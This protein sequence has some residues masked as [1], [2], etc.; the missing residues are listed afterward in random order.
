MCVCMC[1][2]VCV[3]HMWMAV[4]F[5]T[6]IKYFCHWNRKVVTLMPTLTRPLPPHPISY[7]F[8]KHLS[9]LGL[10]HVLNYTI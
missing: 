6:K 3:C 8:I 5:P 7:I 1:G 10:C 9:M 4:D 2:C